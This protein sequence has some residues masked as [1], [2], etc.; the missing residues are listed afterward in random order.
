MMEKEM[1]EAKINLRDKAFDLSEPFN[2][3]KEVFRLAF[4][5]H[6]I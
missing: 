3:T 4:P 5:L 6:R 1:G 2:L